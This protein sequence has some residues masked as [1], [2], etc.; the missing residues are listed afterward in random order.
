MEQDFFV[1][2]YLFICYFAIM[3]ELPKLIQKGHEI[4]KEIPIAARARGKLI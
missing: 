3:A 1:Y 2:I 4:P